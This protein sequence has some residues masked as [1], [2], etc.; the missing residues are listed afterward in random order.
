VRFIA[1]ACVKHSPNPNAMIVY[2]AS[3]QGWPGDVPT[4]RLDPT[5]LEQLGFRLRYTSNEALELAV[6]EV[7]AETFR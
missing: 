1:E 6:G 3:A 4:S 2:G 5:K 7:A